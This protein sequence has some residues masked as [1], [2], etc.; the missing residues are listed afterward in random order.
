MDISDSIHDEY[1]SEE[2]ICHEL[3][4]KSLRAIIRNE[5]MPDDFRQAAA[6]E[7]DYRQSTVEMNGY[8]VPD[9]KN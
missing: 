2:H 1:I 8:H 6:F 5:S 3:S 4:V 9:D 7:Y